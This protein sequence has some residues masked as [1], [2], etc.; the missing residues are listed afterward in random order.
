MSLKNVE[1]SSGV[2]DVN[3]IQI[4]YDTFGQKHDPALLLIMGGCVQ[5]IFWT[6]DFCARFANKG[7]YVIRYDHRDMGE[8]TYIDF[9]SQPYDLNDMSKDAVELLN[10]LSVEKAHLLGLSTGGLIAQIMAVDYPTKVQSITVW[11]TSSNFSPLIDALEGNS[12]NT[13]LL[14]PPKE[15]YLDCMKTLLE[16]PAKDE[17]E[18]L[19]QRIELWHILSGFSAPFDEKEARKLHQLFLNRQK[20]MESLSHHIFAQ[21]RSLDM[22]NSISEKVKVPTLV[23]HGTE[24]P[25]F[26]PEHGKA[27]S[28]AIDGSTYKL[29]EGLGHVPNSY[30]DEIIVNL[31]IEHIQ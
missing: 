12:S 27:L 15:S 29:I 23:I 31:V 6:E 5:G 24:D 21:N 10:S 28:M 8:S 9:D 16:N 1:R 20:N 30:F 7:N 13:H 14:P 22:I 25:I 2:V 4:Y 19:E 3:G 11:A 26:P 17:K 18:L